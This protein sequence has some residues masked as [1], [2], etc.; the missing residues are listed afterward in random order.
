MLHSLVHLGLSDSARPTDSQIHGLI[1]KQLINPVLAFVKAFR[2]KG[3]KSVISTR[4]DASMISLA[5]KA[6]WNF[7]GPD[8]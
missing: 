3:D 4:F 8:P 7:S 2:L 6:V 1:D 5:I